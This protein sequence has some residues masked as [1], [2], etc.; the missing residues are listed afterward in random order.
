MT[1]VAPN[2][3][4]K[5]VLVTGGTRGIGL[6]T[7]LAF[8]RCGAQCV[9]TYRWGSVPVEEVQQLFDDE[10]LRT[11]LVVQANAAEPADTTK[12]FETVAAQAGPLYAFISNA[13]NAVVVSELSDLNRRAFR[14]TM[15]AS[16]WPTFDVIQ[17]HHAAFDQHPRYVVVMSSDGPDRFAVGYDLVAASKAALEA[18]C[19]YMAHR[20]APQGVALNVIRSR[21][22]KTDALAEVFGDDLMSFA[23]TVT[24]PSDALDPED[25][26][27][28]ALMLC[29]GLMD[30]MT[31][32]IVTVDKGTSFR[33]NAMGFFVHQR[34]RP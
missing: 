9:L 1:T 21:G 25:V 22:V 29:S 10:G 6:A 7:A 24:D 33:D 14:R 28:V 13:A 30:G 4:G 3:D 8:A 16:T 27:N 23:E 5:V 34:D 19:R 11:P 2:L 31:G 17:A 12:L 15:D 20:L 26:A 32:Q 18:M